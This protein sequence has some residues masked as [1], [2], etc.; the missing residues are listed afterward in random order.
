MGGECGKTGPSAGAIYYGKVQSDTPEG[1]GNTT[2]V[3]PLV[4]AQAGIQK[5]PGNILWIPACER[6]KK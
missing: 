6:V 2:P 3:H 5:G 4:P 1:Q